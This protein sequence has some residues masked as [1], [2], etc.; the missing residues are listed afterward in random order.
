MK[1]K[2]ILS[3][4]LL[5]AV[6]S[7]AQNNYMNYKAVVKDG[8]GNI[9]ASQN[10]GVQIE[11]L[12]ESAVEYTETHTIMTDVNG[13]MVLE[14]GSGSS[15][16]D[17]TSINWDRFYDRMT[18]TFYVNSLKVGID[19]TGGTA[20]VDLDPTEFKSVPYA[21]NVINGGLYRRGEGWKLEHDFNLDGE[22][23]QD[24]GVWAIDMTIHKDG[25]SNN[26]SGAWGDFS[27]AAGQNN[28]ASGKYS[29]A[30]GSNNI[31][32]GIGSVAFGEG[33]SAAAK[34]SFAMGSYNVGG[35]NGTS[36][37]DTD[38]IFEIGNG[39]S[40]GFPSNALTIL[41]NGTITA[42]SITNALIN[43]AGNKALVTKE[44][45]DALSAGGSGL[46]AI[47][48]G[49]GIGWRLIGRN[50][51]DYATIGQDAI[52]F[53]T[54]FGGFW[55][56]AGASGP[57]S[58]ATGLNN[59][60][61]GS[62]S[63]AFGF[64]N[65]ADGGSSLVGGFDSRA[66]GDYSFAI[67]NDAQ[68]LSEGAVAFGLESRASGSYSFAT[69]I[70]S[71]ASGSYSVAFNGEAEGSLA[72]AIHGKAIGDSSFAIGGEA[73]GVGSIALG[74]TVVTGTGSMAVGSYNVDNV[75][76]AFMVGNGTGLSSRSNALQVLKNG[77]IQYGSVEYIKDGGGFETEINGGLYPFSD[78]SNNLGKATN[79]WADVYATNGTIQTS[80]RRDKTNMKSIEY[81]LVKLMQL[82]PISFNWKSAPNGATKLGLVAQD[83]L[84]VI[85]E[86]VKTHTWEYT[87]ENDRSKKKLV[88]LER[89]GVYYSDLIPVLIKAIQ[90]QQGT[91]EGLKA[92]IT[93]LENN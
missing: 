84:Q 53:S 9:V 12:R 54:S 32:S 59:A 16:D 3:I 1:T 25:P 77:N 15:T 46:E 82:Q 90:E 51:T 4:A 30:L 73:I 58:L 92:R 13:I 63:M 80:D 6:T 24:P 45:V 11:I 78:G 91:I 43:T 26:A 83:L 37:V 31:T 66:S 27:F 49:G 48:E 21:Y 81:G 23:I 70:N 41:K 17:F 33:N 20:Y 72:F 10:I 55:P 47:N 86:V 79:R 74:N 85:P 52:D 56:D 87:D 65:R 29:V 22:I 67:G 14:I 35:G 93:V 75:N 8:S 50:P 64:E 57:G 61:T 68:A 71:S 88:E 7:F 18:S 44:Y 40:E 39:I 89:M 60:V 69:G 5:I 38:P 62:S 2:L 36:W 28:L 42:P 34:Y 19:I 76:A